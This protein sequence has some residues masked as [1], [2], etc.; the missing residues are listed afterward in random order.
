[1]TKKRL[2]IAWIIIILASVALAFGAVA[3]GDAM[4]G[5]GGIQEVS[6]IGEWTEK[7]TDVKVSFTENGAM[8]IAD[9][10]AAS[11]TLD[12][13]AHL[14]NI[15]YAADFGGQ[16]L[17]WKYEITDQ[18]LTLTDPNTGETQIYTR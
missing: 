16:A 5:K 10:D 14:I 12:Q 1:M 17:S 6:I 2:I 3:I 7:S 11:Y 13:E 18:Q 9:Q 15:Q 8:R 4:K